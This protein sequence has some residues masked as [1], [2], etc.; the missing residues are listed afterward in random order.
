MTLSLQSAIRNHLTTS[1]Q[2]IAAGAKAAGISYISFSKLAKGTAGGRKVQTRVIK[3]LAAWM[4]MDEAQLAALPRTDADV[5][6][7]PPVLEVAA[8]AAPVAADP[9]DNADA[10]ATPVATP[11]AAAAPTAT[12]TPSREQVAAVL[13]AIEGEQPLVVE[14]DGRTLVLAGTAALRAWVDGRIA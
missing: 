5:P 1:N 12:S 4:N 3:A 8:E 10:A 14:A 6:A 13:A 2:S 7:E 11:A 9:A